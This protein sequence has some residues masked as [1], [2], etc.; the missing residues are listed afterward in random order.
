ALS[1]SREQGKRPVQVCRQRLTYLNIIGRMESFL[2]DPDWK[3]P[4]GRDMAHTG[5]FNLCHNGPMNKAECAYCQMKFRFR[6]PHEDPREYHKFMSPTCRYLKAF[7]D[8][9]TKPS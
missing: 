9:G 6:T 7:G 3:G 5:L 8:H 1:T 2:N 4:P